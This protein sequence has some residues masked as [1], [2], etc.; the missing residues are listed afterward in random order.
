[1]SELVN[2]RQVI[3]SGN[4]YPNSIRKME[5]VLRAQGQIEPLQVKPYC[6]LQDGTQVYITYLQDVHGCDIVHAALNLGWPTIL[7]SVQT[8]RY[9]Y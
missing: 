9:E 2:P 5:A 3:P 6:K 4:S 8:G 1:M 7:V